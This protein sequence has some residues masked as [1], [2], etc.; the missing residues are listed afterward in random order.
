CT[1]PD[2]SGTTCDVWPNAASRWNITNTQKRIG[3]RLKGI[4]N[5]TFPTCSS[6]IGILDYA[7]RVKSTAPNSAMFETH[8]GL[9]DIIV[10]QVQNEND[11]TFP[12]TRYI[13]ILDTGRRWSK[14]F[15]PTGAR[16]SHTR[17]SGLR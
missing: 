15:E 16:N 7:P 11:S 4:R 14:T 9:S 6:R 17:L 10:V 2:C 3:H 8:P 5:S 12:R 13:A 1:G